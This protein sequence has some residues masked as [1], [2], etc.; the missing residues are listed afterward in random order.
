MQA[1][2]NRQPIVLLFAKAGAIANRPGLTQKQITD[3]RGVSAKRWV[4]SSEDAPKERERAAADPDPKDER[5]AAHGYGTHNV[6]PGDHVAFEAGAFSGHGEV[7]SAGKDGVQVKDASGRV[8]GVHWSEVRGF[9]GADG[10]KKPDDQREVRGPRDPVPAEAFSAHE[11]KGGHDDPDATVESVLKAFP[12]DTAGKIDAASK[13]LENIEQTQEKYRQADGSYSPERKALHDKILFEG[14]EK[15]DPKSGE[16]KR[17][18]GLFAS[19]E[20][21]APA[22]GEQ[23]T[24]VILGGRGGS[25]KSQFEG[26][27][28]D[29]ARTIVLD[30]DHI[31]GMLPEYEGWNAHQVHE[32][33]SDILE[34]ALSIARDAGL[35]V[36]LD[37]TMKTASSA[38]EKV[39]SFK[40]AG[41]RTEAHYMHLPRQEA[42]KRA[43]ARFLGK[44]ARFVPPKVV[45]GNTTNE[46]SFDEVK[47]MVDAWS[48][49][50]NNVKQGEDPIL[51]SAKG[52]PVFGKQ[53]DAS[54]KHDEPMRKAAPG[55]MILLWRTRK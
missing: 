14:V 9:Q 3:K 16:K 22:D 28:Y 5:G 39:Q 33:S 21:A 15:T 7:V 10:T 53:Q 32:E 48:F 52:D 27:V 12:P 55:G 23:P 30:A 49:R 35:H 6:E 51:I 18:A 47:R 4:R 44:T 25:G 50:D 20:R 19:M 1:Q 43:V 46:A 54:S 42:A 41:Y 29:P 2:E 34:R 37:A 24:F 36:V 40:D 38:I 11:W 17:I 8:H 26:M 45:L 31:K 13:R